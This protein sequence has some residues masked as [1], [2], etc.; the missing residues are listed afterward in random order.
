MEEAARALCA[1]SSASRR[2][3]GSLISMSEMGDE[4]SPPGTAA[5]V[6]LKMSS[7]F[8]AGGEPPPEALVPTRGGDDMGAGRRVAD[9]PVGQPEQFGGL[10][11]C[12]STPVAKL[13]KCYVSVRRTMRGKD[14]REETLLSYPLGVGLSRVGGEGKRKEGR[15]RRTYAT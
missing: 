12:V 4:G 5:K 7:N 14:K 15:K 11:T 2:E 1:R 9:E 3:S 8:N 10:I 13:Q 6:L